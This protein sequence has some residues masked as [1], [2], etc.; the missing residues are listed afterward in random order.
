MAK[1]DFHGLVDA[2]NVNIDNSNMMLSACKSLYSVT[3]GVPRNEGL[4]LLE[5]Y[6]LHPILSSLIL[7]TNRKW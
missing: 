4:N 1:L 7:P 2:R 5:S 6:M 3:A